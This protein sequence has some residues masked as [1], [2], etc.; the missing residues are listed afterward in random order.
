MT[1]SGRQFVCAQGQWN[2]MLDMWLHEGHCDMTVQTQTHAMMPQHQT[3]AMV[4]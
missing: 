2:L 1:R 4:L 3:Y